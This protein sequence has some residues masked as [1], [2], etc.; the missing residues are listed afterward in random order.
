MDLKI[1]CVCIGISSD[2]KNMDRYDLVLKAYQALYR[3]KKEGKNRICL[4]E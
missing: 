4:C 3:A 1:V 2:V